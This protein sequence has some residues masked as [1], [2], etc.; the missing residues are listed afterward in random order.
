MTQAGALA[1]LDHIDELLG[2]VDVLKVQRDRI[3]D[4]L[5]SLGYRVAPS[6]ANFVLFGG[7]DDQ[8]AVWQQ[9]VDR[10]VLIRD[11]RLPGYLRVTAG[12]PHE[13]EEF[14]KAIRAIT[15]ENVA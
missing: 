13:T 5:R 6:D 10:G 1:A 15:E 8:A 2:R 7:F 4:D 3:S 12:T 9:L 11:L 14:L